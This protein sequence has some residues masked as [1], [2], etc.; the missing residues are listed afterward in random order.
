MRWHGKYHVLILW[1][2]SRNFQLAIFNENTMIF[3][4][5]RLLEKFF[6]HEFTSTL[7]QTCV[8]TVNIYQLQSF[9]SVQRRMQEFV[10]LV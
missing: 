4:R 2:R 3:R 10:S 6:A 5:S 7:S 1:L 9:T 8:N